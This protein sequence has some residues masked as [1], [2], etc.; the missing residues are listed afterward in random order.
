MGLVA[1]L[2]AGV[3]GET[4][5]SGL[6]R[7]GYQA[8]DLL[9]AERRPERAA[10]LAERYGIRATAVNGIVGRTRICSGCGRPLG[11]FTAAR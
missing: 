8:G 5:L 10:E 9:V 7:S 3:M 11:I 2:G 4:L 6:L 1:V